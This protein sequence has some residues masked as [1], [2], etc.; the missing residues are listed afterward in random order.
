MGGR[1]T[2]GPV[3]RRALYDRRHGHHGLLLLEHGVAVTVASHH[4]ITAPQL[5]QRRG[6]TDTVGYSRLAR[7]LAG[8]TL[9]ERFRTVPS[10]AAGLDDTSITRA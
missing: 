4:N 8:P 6:P 5:T 10:R 9:A 3:V 2:S 1:R 7:G